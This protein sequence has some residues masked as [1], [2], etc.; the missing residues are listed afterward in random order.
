MRPWRLFSCAAAALALA[1]GGGDKGRSPRDA[2]GDGIADVD[3]GSADVDGDGIPNRLDDDSDGDGY[4]DADEA[5]DGV[6]PRD[7]DRDGVP[8]FLDIDADGDGAFDESERLGPDGTAATGDETDPGVP[9]SD[10]DGFS[11]GGEAASGS[12]PADAGRIPNGVYAVLREGATKVVRVQLRTT[13]PAVD[14]AFLIDTTGSMGE[15]IAAVRDAFAAIAREVSLHVPDA[16]FGVADYRDYAVS[17]YGGGGDVPY[18]L[19]QQITSDDGRVFE[20]LSELH[21]SG[22][23]D[24]P[25]SQYEALYQLA[26]GRGFDL[27]GDRARQT[28]DVRPFLSTTIDAFGGRVTGSFDPDSPGFGLEGGI[29]FREGVFRLAVHASDAPFHDPDAG[30]SL[31]NAGTPPAGRLAAIDALRSIGVHVIGVASG[32]P[33]VEQMRDIARETGAIADRDGDG[34]ADDLLVYSVESDGAGLPEAVTDGIVKML[35]S[36]T[37]DVG[38]GVDGDKWEFVAGSEPPRIDSVHPGETVSFDVTLVGRITSG[39]EDRIYRFSIL[40]RGLDGTILDRVPAVVVVPHE[41]RW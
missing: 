32:V 41:A 3:E 22:G 8:D 13:I 26:L 4:S 6:S 11:D 35:T 38:I 19:R 39:R 24:Y 27:N 16:Q 28:A 23:G 37:F 20:A 9:D 31:G 5:G 14:V 34:A 12:N 18:R 10:G 40:L 17:P 36:T 33:P 29:G 21:A 25:E 15:E 2:D 7:T 1:C 30:W